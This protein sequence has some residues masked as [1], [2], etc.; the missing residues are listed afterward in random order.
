MK[1]TFLGA[2]GEVTG[3]C[4]LV[5]T[6]GIRFLIDCGMFQGR[7]AGRRNAQFHFDPRAIAFVLLTHAHIDHSG[8]VPRLVARG[9]KGPV[10][11]TR[12][13]CDLLGVMLPD[14]GHLQEREAE[15]EGRAPLYTE[16]DAR[17]SLHRLDPVEY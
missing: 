2:A 13:T 16:A 3:S 17:S 8:L 14:S 6:G 15:R 12:A 10:Y 9:F 1:L 11:A 5:E 7:D 4:Y